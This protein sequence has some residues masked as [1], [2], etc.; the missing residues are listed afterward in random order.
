MGPTKPGLTQSVREIL[1]I[2]ENPISGGGG[3]MKKNLK[4]KYFLTLTEADPRLADEL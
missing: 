1:R 3:K 2:E 4:E